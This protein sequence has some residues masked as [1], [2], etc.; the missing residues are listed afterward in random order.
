VAAIP[1]TSSGDCLWHRGRVDFSSPTLDATRG[2]LLVRFGARVEPWWE[3]LPGAIAEL[4]ARWEL[5]VG[6][7][8]G[9]GNTSL[10]VRCRRADGRP[11]V[12]KLTP[13]AELGATEASALRRWESSG[14]VPLV[15]GHD[16]ALGALLLEAI[17]SETSIAERRTA[18]ALDQVANLIGELH[19][20][21][22]PVVADGWA[23]LAARVEFIFDH[24]VERH[25]RRGEVATRAVPVDRLRRGH[26][27][28]RAL[29]A[30]AGEPVLLHGDL[31]P[32][33][34]LDGGAVRGLVAIDPRPCVGD[35]PVDAVDWVFWAVD[36]PGAWE[37]RS[38]DLA[39]ALGLDHE[40]LWTWCAAFAAMLAASRAA[41]GASAEQ[42][43]ALLALSP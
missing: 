3:R 11:A 22:A 31:H 19:R 17:P 20:S 33:N 14:R 37:P 26:E 21:G 28:A 39:V 34:V 4:A 18:V 16:A 32:G 13:D 40:R 25:G 42:V 35:A 38:R 12:L 41:R 27:L 6:E 7:A 10:V 9:R 2:R 23:P 15:W 29:A 8:V 24:W 30:D 36:D 43:A 1:R 5:V